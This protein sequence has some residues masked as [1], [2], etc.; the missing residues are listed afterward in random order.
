MSGRRCEIHRAQ[1]PLPLTPAN[2]VA[3]EVA[4][5]VKDNEKGKPKRA[6]TRVT[7]LHCDLIRD[8]FWKERPYIMSE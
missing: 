1:Y 4:S 8:E 5:D 3:R 2:K 6:L 7:V